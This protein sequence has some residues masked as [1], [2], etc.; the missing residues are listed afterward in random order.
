MKPRLSACPYCGE[1]EVALRKDDTT[2]TIQWYVMC[3]RCGARGPMAENKKYIIDR[4]NH[5]AHAIEA[6]RKIPFSTII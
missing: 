1:D 6:I 3:W 5:I 4:Y 2:I